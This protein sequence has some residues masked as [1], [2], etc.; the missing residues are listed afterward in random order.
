MGYL[1][2]DFIAIWDDCMEF[3]ECLETLVIVSEAFVYEAEVVYCFDTVGFNTD[4][5]QEE[6]LSTIVV[7]IDEETVTFVN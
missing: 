7:F 5:F 1:V 2:D 6:F 4:G 3:L